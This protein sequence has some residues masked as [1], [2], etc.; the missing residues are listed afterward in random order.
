MLF[1]KKKYN[2]VFFL[3]LIIY[4]KNKII[5]TYALISLKIH[6]L[7]FFLSFATIAKEIR[8]TVFEVV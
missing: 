8:Y 7:S 3:K 2:Y 6:N 4:L 1:L 5:I